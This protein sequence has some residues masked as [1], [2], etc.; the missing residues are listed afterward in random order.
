MVLC[1]RQT[2][3]GFQKRLL[4]GFGNPCVESAVPKAIGALAVF[5][6][7]LFVFVKMFK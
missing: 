4:R 1:I 5:S 7:L 3:L 6:G 2:P